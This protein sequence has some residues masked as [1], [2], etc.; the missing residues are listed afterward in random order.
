MK[1]DIRYANH[2][3]DMKHYDTALLRSHFLFD[4]VFI[5]G[6]I[7][8]CYTHV[9]RMVFG[10]ACPADRELRLEGAKN[11]AAACFWTTGN[12]GSSVLPGTDLFPGTGRNTP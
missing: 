7:S 8:L 4:R 2:A 10:G 5:P 12:W 6:E 9:D 1:L 3:D 11:S